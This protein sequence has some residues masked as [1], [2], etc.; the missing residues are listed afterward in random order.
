MPTLKRL[1]FITMENENDQELVDLAVSGN[2]AAFARLIERHYDMIFRIAFKWCGE[3]SDAEDIAQDVCVKLGTVISSYK[4][5]AAF[6]SWLYRIT[7]NAVRDFQRASKRRHDNM[8]A[9]AVVVQTDYRPDPVLEMTRTQ[10]WHKVRQL[11]PKQR[12]TM[13]LIYAED[14]SHAEAAGIMECAESTVSWHVHE[15]KKRLKQEM[16]D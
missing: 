12:D 15:A 4:G 13:L 1:T 5:E 9:L 16:Q 2:A 14:L 10:M 8:A 11:P 3:R 7:L 6:S